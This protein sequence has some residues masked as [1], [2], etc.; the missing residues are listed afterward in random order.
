[1]PAVKELELPDAAAMGV[2]VEGSASAWPGASDAA[3]LPE[4]DVFNRPRRYIDVFNK[5]KAPFD[6][7]ARASAA[8]ITL[9]AAKGIVEKE[10]RL[11]V[12]ADWSKAPAGRSEGTVTIAGPD[13]VEVGV[14]V[15]AWNPRELTPAA[16]GFV[17]ADGYVS[18]E[19]EHYSKATAVGAARWEKIDGYGRTLSA[20]SVFPVL[21]P[22]AM[23]GDSSPSLEYDM[24]LF[25]FGKAEV[26]AILGPTQ[27]FVP[28]RGLRFAM[29]FDE[30]PPQVIDTLEHNTNRD[31]ETS[32]KDAVRYVKSSFPIPAPGRHTLKVWMVDPGIA[33]EKILVDL[34]GLKPSYLGPPESFRSQ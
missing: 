11:W 3:T 25:H 21:A 14:K 7:T 1:M 19:A 6:F 16:P 24:Y 32:V 10:V 15:A 33:L 13:G 5:G 27:N 17:E 22:S 8:W 23:P 9:S 28:G 29:A 20:M 30:Q 2:A 4:L 12:S 18:I 26:S 34:G 31:W